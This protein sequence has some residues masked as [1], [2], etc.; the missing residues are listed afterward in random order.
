LNSSQGDGGVLRQPEYRSIGKGYIR[1]ASVTHPNA[2]P[3]T[4]DI[5]ENHRLP[6]RDIHTVHFNSS[7]N[8]HSRS[9][10]RIAFCSR[11]DGRGKSDCQEADA[12]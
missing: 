2:I 6:L 9:H 12:N 10:N 11:C 7:L 3:G 8:G 4:E 5:V 1:P